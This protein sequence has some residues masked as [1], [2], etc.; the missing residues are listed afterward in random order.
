MQ[1]ESMSPQNWTKALKQD[2]TE[3]AYANELWIACNRTDRDPTTTEWL[4]DV[5]IY[6]S[7]SNNG[8]DIG[9]LELILES[10]YDSRE[11]KIKEDLQKLFVGRARLRCYVFFSGDITHRNEIFSLIERLTTSNPNVEPHDEYLI[12]GWSSETKNFDYR[13]LDSK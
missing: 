1:S 5:V 11:E 7:E 3:L 10:E 12:A 8:I 13:I 4:W 6:Q 2:L 9:K